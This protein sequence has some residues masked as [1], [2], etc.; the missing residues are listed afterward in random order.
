MAFEK[1]ELKKK[2]DVISDWYTDVIL[3]AEVADYGPTKGTM[4]IRPYGFSIWEKVQSILDGW[5]KENGV[6]NAYFPLL[7]PDRKS[8]RTNNHGPF[9]GAIVS[10]FC[11]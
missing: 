9:G 8:V 6:G 7:F 11:F 5:F 1:K 4:V 3:K 2:S 10:N